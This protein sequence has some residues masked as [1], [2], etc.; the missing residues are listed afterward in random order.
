MKRTINRGSLQF[1]EMTSPR[2]GWQLRADEILN[3][4]RERGGRNLVNEFPPTIDFFIA[5][6]NFLKICG[7]LIIAYFLSKMCLNCN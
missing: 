4:E 2:V 6:M 5:P 7:Y 3:T 1:K